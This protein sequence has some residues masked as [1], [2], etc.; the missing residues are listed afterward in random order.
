MEWKMEFDW[1]KDMVEVHQKKKRKKNNRP[2]VL[3]I[4]M[5]I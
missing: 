3:D 5:N 1:N 2:L 4:S